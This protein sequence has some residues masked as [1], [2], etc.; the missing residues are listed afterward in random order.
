MAKYIGC[1]PLSYERDKMVI[2]LEI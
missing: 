2:R 1:R